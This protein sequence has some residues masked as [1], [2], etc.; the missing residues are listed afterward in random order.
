MLV[1]SVCGCVFERGGMAEELLHCS[2]IKNILPFFIWNDSAKVL[3]DI[4][5]PW[6]DLNGTHRQTAKCTQGAV[7]KRQ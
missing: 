4:L 1:S 7:H 6:K 2:M 5:V 3:C